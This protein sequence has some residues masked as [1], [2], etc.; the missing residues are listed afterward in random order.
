MGK[1]LL[2]IEQY[3]FPDGW[4]GAQYPINIAERMV[5]EGWKVKVI[6]GNVPYVIDNYYK[7]DP[8]EN[9]VII[10]YINLPVPQKNV[11]LKLINQIY[12]S[13]N[14]FLKI[15]LNKKPNLIIT[16]TNPPPIIIIVFLVKKI[17][18]IPYIVI[19]MD[20]YPE[21]LLKN[22]SK[23]I[24]IILKTLI[25]PIFNIAYRSASRVVSLGKSMSTQLRSKGISKSKIVIIRNWGL[26]DFKTIKAP[27]KLS[28]EWN[29]SSEFNL[30]YSGNLGIAHEWE[31]LLKALRL[32][33][34]RSD[35][36]KILF[37]SSGTR[38]NQAKT[39]A[40]TFLPLNSVI[41]KP[42]V[43]VENLP[44]TMG[45]ADMAIVTLR[46]TYDGLV[47]PSKLS[48]Y[49]ARGLPILFIGSDPELKEIIE[50]N[51]AGAVFSPGDY[52]SLTKYLISIQ[53]NKSKLL[54]QGKNAMSYYENNISK[55]KGLRKYAELI[56]NYIDY[57]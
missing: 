38:I 25:T 23:K 18:K 11:F 33:K 21:V 41:F 47:S 32:S 16:L 29:I 52:E 42:L 45:L 56:N 36:L 14:C 40:K 50:T 54:R 46:S 44:L 20:L 51:D 13:L 1:E 27:N 10:E 26:G 39:F 43:K 31:T 19:A 6:C 28:K 7:N 34:L 57:L 2:L 48:G 5:S 35:Q 37:I 4:T 30:I 17:Y 12:F 53:K 8:R 15:I 55:E 3:F 22:L 9:G 24:S 49:L